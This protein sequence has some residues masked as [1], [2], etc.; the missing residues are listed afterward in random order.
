MAVVGGY[1]T[2]TMRGE[3]GTMPND[4]VFYV[5]PGALTSWNPQLFQLVSTTAV[6]TG[7]YS[8]TPSHSSSFVFH[9]ISSLL[10]LL[11][12]LSFFFIFLYRG[13]QQYVDQPA[14]LPGSQLRF[15]F[16]YHHPRI[17]STCCL[18]GYRSILRQ[19]LHPIGG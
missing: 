10:L 5:T 3:T 15:Q 19:P 6:L 16:L 9:L 12:L 2:V 11:L 14:P 8:F 17:Q 18:F 13:Q 4:G 7:K 1:I